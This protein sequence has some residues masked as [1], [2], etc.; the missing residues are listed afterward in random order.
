MWQRPRRDER[1]RLSHDAARRAGR[2]HQHLLGSDLP[3]VGDASLR[4]C[5]Q[6]GEVFDVQS[7]IPLGE[8]VQTISN[9]PTTVV[10]RTALVV[11][12]DPALFGVSRHGAD[13]PSGV[14]AWPPRSQ[15]RGPRRELTGAD[16]GMAHAP[17][18][19][20]A[21]HGA[22]G[23]GVMSRRPQQWRASC[24]SATLAG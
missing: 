5:R 7:R 1:G 20:A 2:D 15:V 24:L 9:V 4:V 22:L 18:S 10:D 3:L 6:S 8:E 16:A 12:R 17:V 11:D 13:C 23:L 14:P 19:P 21:S